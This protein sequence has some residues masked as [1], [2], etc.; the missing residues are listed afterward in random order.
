LRLF[1]HRRMYRVAILGRPRNL[2][3][4][5]SVVVAV[6]L[7][8]P[9]QSLANR[10]LLAWRDQSVPDERDFVEDALHRA[11]VRAGSH[12]HSIRTL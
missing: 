9:Q 7:E 8:L 11:V 10:R 4:H 1:L 12:V 5:K 3:E 2:P 6:P